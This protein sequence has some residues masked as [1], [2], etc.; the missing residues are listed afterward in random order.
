MLAFV[1]VL[2][3]RCAMRMQHYM[4]K[5]LKLG[6]DWQLHLKQSLRIHLHAALLFDLVADAD[7]VYSA[8]LEAQ[9][10]LTDDDSSENSA[11]ILKRALRQQ[12]MNERASR[13]FVVSCTCYSMHL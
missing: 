7:D 4:V 6:A 12:R 8:V 10:A 2:A 11:L 9:L 13:L 3:M 5:T 1:C